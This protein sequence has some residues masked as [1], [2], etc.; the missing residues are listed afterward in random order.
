[1][2]IAAVALLVALSARAQVREV[3]DVERATLVEVDGG[4]G[5]E[6]VGGC[7]LSS[8]RCISSAR[9]IARCRAEESAATRIPS[10]P[11]STVLVVTGAVGL[12]AFLAGVIVG[13]FVVR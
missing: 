8:E 11:V 3:V 5:L 7:W 9:E 13:G 12:V 6:V 2:K 1:M 4:V 10:S